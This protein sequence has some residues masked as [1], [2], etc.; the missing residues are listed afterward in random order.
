MSVILKGMNM[1]Q[2]CDECRFCIK[3]ANGFY[4]YLCDLL[5]MMY[6]TYKSIKPYCPLV[7][8]PKNHGRIIDGDAFAKHIQKVS[9]NCNYKNL[10][11]DGRLLTVT[12][13]LDAV[14][15]DLTGKGLGG[16]KDVP[17]ILEAE[18]EEDEE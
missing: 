13:V 8:I 6:P 5:N 1:P 10:E 14:V 12:D 17:T 16:F 18:S 11:I 2:S 3:T 7:E 15:A 9:I 4:P